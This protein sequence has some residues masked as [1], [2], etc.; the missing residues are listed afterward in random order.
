MSLVLYYSEPLSLC[1]GGVLRG[2]YKVSA[3]PPVARMPQRTVFG[4]DMIQLS[5][6]FS[7]WRELKIGL[8]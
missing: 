8:G 1:Y 5:F 6:C 2:T 3:I 7:I 4:V